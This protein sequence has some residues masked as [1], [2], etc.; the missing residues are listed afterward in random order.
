[1]TDYQ[2]FTSCFPQLIIDE[3]HFNRLAAAE[4]ARFFREEGGFAAVCGDRISL[5]CV[6][7]EYQHRGIG[8]SLLK[9]CEQYISASCNTIRLS[10]NMLP[11]AVE[12][13]EEFFRKKG[14]SMDGCYNEMSLELAEF[15]PPQHQAPEGAE[16]RFYHGDIQPLRAAVAAVEEDW[17]QYFNEGELFF[18]CLVD[19]EIACFCIVGEDEDCLLSD[20]RRIGSIGCVGTVPS[21]RQQGLGLYMVALGSQHLKD[22]GCER[23]FIH[24]THLDKWYGKLGATTFLRFLPAEK[25]V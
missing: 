22:I 11:G 6:A 15:L 8:S 4:E 9:Q 17:V 12:G 7:P 25:S 23:V 19:G 20:G 16:F 18:C 5:L 21:F 10:G 3:Q 2:I 14:Y 24:F 13:S 1:M